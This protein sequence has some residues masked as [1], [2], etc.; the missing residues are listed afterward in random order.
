MHETIAKTL[1]ALRKRKLKAWYAATADDARRLVLGMTPLDALVGIGDSS[2]V[3]QLGIVEGL[4]A[5]GNK[6][7]NPFD[8]AHVPWD[9]E[10]FFKYLFWPTLA[11]TLSDI[12]LTGSNAVTE[13]GKIVN[14]DGAATG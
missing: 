5:R 4:E 1:K 8:I 3:R 2:T 6:V 12:F 9:K 7:I 13:D 11:A 10:S 14:V